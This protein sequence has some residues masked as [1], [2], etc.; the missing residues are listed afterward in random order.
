MLSSTKR[1]GHPVAR[2][3]QAT[4]PRDTFSPLPGSAKPNVVQ[5]KM[6]ASTVLRDSNLFGSVAS[7]SSKNIKQSRLHTLLEADPQQAKQPNPGINRLG[8][9]PDFGSPQTDVPRERKK[10]L[11]KAMTQ[12][13]ATPTEQ[14]G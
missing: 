12:N 10:S 9:N 7:A 6:M 8:Q 14:E 2:K 3:T 13:I 1:L 5:K 11:N 4:N